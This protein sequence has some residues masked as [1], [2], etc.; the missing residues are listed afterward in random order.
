ML[1]GLEVVAAVVASR[2]FVRAGEV[3]GLTQSGVSRAIARIEQQ[4][5]VRLFDRTARAVSLTDDGRRFYARVAPLLA[6]LHDAIDDAAGAA[7]TV[8]G[9]LRVQI[10]AFVAA[11]VLGPHLGEFLA[12]HPE[13]E[14][15]LVIGDRAGNLVTEGF[16]AAVRF[17]DLP[18]STLV[19]R[20]LLETRILTCAA[21]RYLTRYGRPRHPSELVRH[22]CIRYI[23]PAS[24]RAFPWE[25]HRG[26][27][28]LIVDVDHRLTVND[29]ATGLAVCFA[30]DGIAQVMEL[31]NRERIRAGQLVPLFPRWQDEL[32]PLHV[33]YPSRHLPPA[34]VRAFVDFV[35]RS[36]AAAAS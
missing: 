16:D 29:T 13:L 6:G 33:I 31:G 12:A 8:R 5:G 25:F 7:G 30:G 21:P 36:A 27:K 26:R 35:V 10:H 14:L 15:E 32:Y 23:D 24:G 20:K 19:A 18:P 3:V 9:K 28:R 17:G 2:S 34:K 1:E 11:Y 4:I 22:R